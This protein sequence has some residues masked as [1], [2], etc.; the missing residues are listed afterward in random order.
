[1]GHMFADIFE[2]KSLDLSNFNTSSVITMDKMFANCKKLIS[3]N[4]SN[5]DTSSFILWLVF[6]M[7]VNH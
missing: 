5:F 3:L 6:L 2:I 7:I 1:M 4:L